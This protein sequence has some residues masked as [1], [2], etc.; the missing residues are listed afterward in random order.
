MSFRL[1]T[2]SDSSLS[3]AGSE[4]VSATAPMATSSASDT[5][6]HDRSV[7]NGPP[8]FHPDRVAQFHSFAES[9]N[10]Y[11][12]LVKSFAPSIWELNDVKRG[13]LCMLFGGNL[14]ETKEKLSQNTQHQ[15]NTDDSGMNDD[16]NNNHETKASK[17]H[18]RSEINILLCGDPGMIPHDEIP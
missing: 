4:S 5:H 13:A 1:I 9:G 12:R 17:V 16:N 6:L 11:E 8:M 7:S 10:V 2:A 14:S 15:D 3:P 18:Q